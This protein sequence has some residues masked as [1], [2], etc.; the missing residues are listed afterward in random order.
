MKSFYFLNFIIA[1]I[2]DIVLRDLTKLNY[3]SS[4]KIYFEDKLIT[5]AGFYAG[6]TIVIALAIT[7]ILSKWLLKIVIPKRSN[8]LVQFS[9]LAFIVGFIIDI[10]IEKLEIFGDSLKPFYAQYGSGPLGG[11]SLVFTVVVSYYLSLLLK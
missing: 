9:V 8:Q 5:E 7:S 1:F 3:I 4:L 10:L 6:L 2:S 11:L